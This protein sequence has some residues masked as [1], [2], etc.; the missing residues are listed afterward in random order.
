MK[1]NVAS[2]ISGDSDKSLTKRVND[3]ITPKKRSPLAPLPENAVVPMQN[4]GNTFGS[5]NGATINIYTGVRP[6]REDGDVPTPGCAVVPS[7]ASVYGALENTGRAVAPSAAS[8]YGVLD[9]SGR[10]VVPSAASE[11]GA[12]ENTGWIVVPSAASVDGALENTGRFPRPPREDGDVPTLENFGRGVMPSATLLANKVCSLPIPKIA[13]G[14]KS[15]KTR[16]VVPSAVSVYE[17]RSRR[18]ASYY[19]TRASASSCDVDFESDADMLADLLLSLG[20]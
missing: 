19:A 15:D 11:N 1:R 14:S 13:G 18:A 5:C 9:N 2:L 3:S 17:T 6:P 12:L 20:R 16:D 8:A 7:A 4:Y 10:A